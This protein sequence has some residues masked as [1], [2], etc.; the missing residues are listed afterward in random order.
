MVIPYTIKKIIT[1]QFAVFPENFIQGDPVNMHFN[2]EFSTQ[3]EK[4]LIINV[5]N[6][7]Y[8]QNDKII[9]K[10]EVH[11]LY[12][13]GKEGIEQIKKEHKIP[14][15]FLRYMGTITVGTA[16]GII[17]SKTENT[18]VNQV[19]LPPVDLTKIIKE[20]FVLKQVE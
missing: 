2:L 10:I 14:V 20:D 6:V 4:N 8:S 7:E 9:M 11:C 5:L 3:F 16:R 13:I 18:L 17:A 19:V 12:E 1:P 15:D